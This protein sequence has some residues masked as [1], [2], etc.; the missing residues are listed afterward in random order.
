[1]IILLNN[2]KQNFTSLALM[3]GTT[4]DI[5]CMFLCPTD[6]QDDRSCIHD[7]K[8]FVQQTGYS[9]TPVLQGDSVRPMWSLKLLYL[10]AIFDNRTFPSTH[11]KNN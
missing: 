9:E 5:I 1:M 3:I 6:S 10:Y 2:C 7:L 11:L 4:V 8:F